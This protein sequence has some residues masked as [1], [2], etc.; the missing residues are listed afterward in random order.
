[1]NRNELRKYLDSKGIQT[2]VYYPVSLHLQEV[3]KYLGH[4]RGD[5]PQSEQAQEQVLSLPMYA[6][7]SD[8]QIEEVV[9]AIREFVRG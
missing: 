4:K 1:L 3:Y 5:F 9:R 2:M 7:L 8:E 6:E